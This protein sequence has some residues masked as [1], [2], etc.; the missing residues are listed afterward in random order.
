MAGTFN[1]PANKPYIIAWKQGMV[2]RLR[3]QKNK[4]GIPS[5][6]PTFVPTHRD[7][8]GYKRAASVLN[9]KLGASSTDV[10]MC[11]SFVSLLCSF[12]EMG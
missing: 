8:Q 11:V 1:V 9:V 6:A 5:F 7:K 12:H 3:T 10:R 4:I 2:E